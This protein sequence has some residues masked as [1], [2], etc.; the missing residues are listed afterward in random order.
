[1]P[2]VFNESRHRIFTTGFCRMEHP[3]EL[4]GGVGCDAA[5][6]AMEA[7]ADSWLADDVKASHLP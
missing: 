4:S 7:T 3:H 6:A 5:G 2:N 1:V